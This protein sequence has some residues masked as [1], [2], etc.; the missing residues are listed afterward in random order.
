MKNVIRF[1]REGLG[2]SPY[3]SQTLRHGLQIMRKYRVTRLSILA[4]VVVLLGLGL[5]TGVG[6]SLAMG[7]DSGPPFIPPGPPFVPD[8]LLISFHPGTTPAEIKS[9]YAKYGVVEKEDLDTDPNDDDPEVKLVGVRLPEPAWERRRLIRELQADAIVEYAEL[10]YLLSIELTP[11]DQQFDQLWG[12]HNTGQ[13]GGTSDADIDAPEAWNITTGATGSSVLIVGVIDTGVD[14]NHEDLV[15]N[16]WNNPGECLEPD[17]TCVADG[18]DNDGNGHVDDFHGINAITDSS[19]PMDDHGHGTHVAGTIGARGDNGIGVV[20][21][22]WTVRIAACKFL[23]SFGG[24]TTAGAVKCFKYFNRLK[25]VHGQNVVATNN[26]WGGGGFSQSLKEAMAGLEQPGMAPILHASAAGNSNNDND[27]SPQYPSGYDLANII[28]VAATDRD[29][30]YAGWS[31]FGA[32]SVDLA[33]PGVSILSTV[34]TG[35]CSLCDFTGYSL[36]SGTSMA[37]PHV[38]GSTAL[39]L[40]KYPSLSASQVKQRILSGADDIGNLGGNASKPTLT[41]GR[42]NLFNALEDDPTPP[43][44]VTDL[45]GSGSGLASVTLTW[46]ATGDDGTTGTARSY[47][48]RYSTSPITDAS[49]PTATHAVG[50]PSPLPYGSPE[51]FEVEGLNSGTTYSFALKVRDN[52][53]NESGLSNVAPA[54][55]STGTIVFGDDME[56]GPGGWTVAGAP[57]PD[58]I[59]HQSNNRSKSLSTAWYYGIEVQLNFDTGAANSGTLTSPAINLTGTTEAVLSF[60]H[61]L[62]RESGFLGTYDRARVQLSPDGT[63]W[64]TVREFDTNKAWD[65]VMVDLT[66]Y[67]EGTVYIRFWFDTVDSILNG[68]E[69][70][71]IDDVKVLVE[72]GPTAPTITSTPVTD[73][74]VGQP[75]SYQATATGTPPISWSLVTWPE[76]MSINADTGLVSWTPGTAGSYPVTIRA[77]NVPGFHTQS[78]SISV[79]ALA[80]T[81]TPVTDGVVDQAYSYQA[82]A[83]GTPPISWSLVTWPE[84]MSINA[85]T[86]LVSWTPGAAGSYPVTI[87]AT[88]V[89]GSDTQSYSISVTVPPTITSTPVTDG[90]VGQ[91]YSYQ[92]TATGTPPIIWSLVTAPGGPS[93]DADTGLVSWT[94]GAAGSYPVTI[95]ATNVAGSDTQSYSISV[96]EPP[97]IT[98]TPVTDGVVG[99]PYSY[100]ATATGTPP[101]SW[102]LVTWP[103]GM[104]INADT[105]L[106]SWTLVEA[107]SYPVAIR[108]TN[109]V[110]FDTQSY[111]LAAVTSDVVTITKAE[112]RA[113]GGGR[114]KVEAT[115][116]VPTATLTVVGYGEMKNRG[117]GRYALQVKGVPEP[118]PAWVVVSSDKGGS[119]EGPVIIK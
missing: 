66:P 108:A 83:T 34:P 33:A 25:N 38:A 5:L 42:L 57:A 24:G 55:T 82:T 45:A 64:V 88:N 41:N 54:S 102:S 118:Q 29:D 9:F 53:G 10:N 95:K 65:E 116:T 15:E 77:T 50:E 105:G 49:W 110:G 56:S 67:L 44:T 17:G 47:D 74:V 7:N 84:G 89:A 81:S 22:N 100:Q 39:I 92:A 87:R 4:S 112:W 20:G 68:F 85:G 14:Y 28:A 76:G 90:I 6:A 51:T 103:E 96:T 117:D 23:S 101:I 107:G 43:A 36:L 3:L 52:V 114:L 113:K 31:S 19:D 115:S 27:P 8:E 99:Q 37:T 79:T 73:G 21:V 104:S 18:I 97:T 1:A 111:T 30:L 69:G 86:G 75:Y 59:W 71:Y 70:W 58:G 98:S 91:A 16:I 11:G 106:V 12:L 94:P 32:T 80:I 63:T 40:A 35:N 72:S 60:Y 48:V 62:Q 26:S 119:H 78:F 46:T 13:G 93:I 2:S 109:A 61:W